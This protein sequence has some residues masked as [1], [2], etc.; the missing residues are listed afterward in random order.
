MDW[1]FSETG[2]SNGL[3]DNHIIYKPA[4]ELLDSIAGKVRKTEG[5]DFDTYVKFHYR[6]S[7]AVDFMERH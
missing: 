4:K 7:A 1:G 6:F 2:L 5:V 3:D